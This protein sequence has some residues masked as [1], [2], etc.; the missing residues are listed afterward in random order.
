MATL[1]ETELPGLGWKYVLRDTDAGDRFVLVT[2]HGGKREVYRFAG[3][4]DAPLD[5]FTLTEDEARRFAAM[6][7]GAV[8]APSPRLRAA[9]PPA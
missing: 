2:H 3:D 7:L 8:V 6:L 4:S 9:P 1:E 5:V